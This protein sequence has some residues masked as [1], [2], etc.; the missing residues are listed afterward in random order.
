[1]PMPRAD[2]QARF[3]KDNREVK[4]TTRLT[5]AHLNFQR[6]IL[7]RDANIVLARASRWGRRPFQKRK[8]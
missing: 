1:V 6:R 3:A 8:K 5:E 7:E 2:H 4:K